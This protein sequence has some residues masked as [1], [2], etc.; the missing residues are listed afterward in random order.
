MADTQPDMGV[1]EMMTRIKKGSQ[2]AMPNAD[3]AAAPPEKEPAPGAEAGPDGP[4]GA[5]E[6][7]EHPAG[8]PAGCYTLADFSQGRHE[9][10]LGF[11]Y[12]RI[13]GRRPDARAKEVYLNRLVSGEYTRTEVLGRLAY[14]REGLGKKVRIKGLFPRFAVQ[15]LCRI[16]LAGRAIGVAAAAAALPETLQRL[17]RAEGNLSAQQHRTEDAVRRLSNRI[18]ELE[19]VVREK[20]ATKDEVL[21][22]D[23]RLAPLADTIRRVDNHQLSLNDIQQRLLNFLERAVQPGRPFEGEDRERLAGEAAH[24]MDGIYLD[25][26][27]RFRGTREDIKSRVRVY[28][29]DVN[30]ALV[31]TGNGR[32]VDLGCGRGEWLEVLK[33]NNIQ[34]LGIDRNRLMADRCRD[35]GLNVV[36]ADVL[37]Y[38]KGLD[39]GSLSAVTGLH[40]IEHLPHATLLA[41]LDAV[42]RVLKPGGT[43]IFETPN[44]ENILVGAHLFYTDPTHRTPLV[45]S[46]LEFLMAARGFDRV[47]IRRLHKYSDYF[48][49]SDSDPFKAAHFYNEMDFAVLGTKGWDTPPEAAASPAAGTRA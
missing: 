19:A 47:E 15:M 18:T 14:C 45:P 2:A 9:D 3:S 28:L 33:E 49:V 23:H 37:A 42:F 36:E 41:L 7:S 31:A 1:E 21:D 34:G 35:L 8:R 38:L 13:L 46:T 40:I 20:T 24:L 27:D 29:P 30:A 48:P 6:S 4:A 12:E 32:V 11:A 25:F 17:R 26:E 43:V 22:L 10:F 44:P 5:C 39:A 16:P